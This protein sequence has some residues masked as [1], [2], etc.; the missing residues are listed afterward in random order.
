M[1]EVA[2]ALT[3]YLKR[4]NTNVYKISQNS[5]L[6]RTMMQKMVKGTK[7][8][9][10]KFFRKFCDYL[11]LND[12][13]RKDLIRMFKLEKVGADKYHTRMAVQDLL[14][15]FQDL[16]SVYLHSVESVQLGTAKRPE[17]LTLNSLSTVRS[18]VFYLIEQEMQRENPQFSFD[19]FLCL[20]D[21]IEKIAGLA[22][23]L[24]KKPKLN[25]YV[26][27]ARNLSTQ[28]DTAGNIRLLRHTLATAFTFGRKDYHVYYNYLNITTKD[29]HYV[30]FPHYFI[31]SNRVI[32]ISGDCSR[33]IMLNNQEVTDDYLRELMYIREHSYNFFEHY[34]TIDEGIAQ[35]E[36][37]EQQQLSF[38]FTTSPTETLMLKDVIDQLPAEAQKIYRRVSTNL[39][40]QMT[41][42]LKW[43][44]SLDG[45]DE[46]FKDG[47][48]PDHYQNFMAPLTKKQ[49]RQAAETF[50]EGLRKYPCF[51][52][53]RDDRLFKGAH[54]DV[55]L[56]A[57]K[58]LHFYSTAVNMPYG[59]LVI[60][61]GSIY[62]AFVDYFE[63]LI[64][65]G[66][67]YSPQDTP[68]QVEKIFDH[69][70]ERYEV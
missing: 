67:V 6:D 4:S 62:N 9:S 69:L 11:I 25:E 66:S 33:G 20:P 48:L 44:F 27:L 29:Y 12:D 60:K 30:L 40:K 37:I 43:I 70:M 5:S 46:F 51:Y 57:P 64:E 42:G 50:V 21:C 49:R 10:L 23:Y 7:L 2:K 13:E 53:I 8:P 14:V 3:K 19:S 36:A 38:I 26:H 59:M 39:E 35:Y 68:D 31:T 28:N 16:R 55:R 63:S 56:A 52:L 15:H 24:D 58:A 17:L 47:L 45:M 41:A 22:H 61:E 34:F 32:C 18:A 65:D 54:V 1:S